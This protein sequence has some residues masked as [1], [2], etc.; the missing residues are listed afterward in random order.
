MNSIPAEVV[1]VRITVDVM[2]VWQ[3]GMTGAGPGGTN[4]V[5]DVEL[6]LRQEGSRVKGDIIGRL[7]TS[8][9]TILPG[10]VPIEGT[11][12]ADKFSFQDVRGQSLRADFQVN[13]DEMI[14]SGGRLVRIRSLWTLRSKRCIM[15]AGARQ[16]WSGR[17][18]PVPVPTSRTRPRAPATSQRR[19]SLSPLHSQSEQMIS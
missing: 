11:V 5:R 18:R 9:G 7:G 16:P 3:G 4:Y 12:S 6:V 2:G 8:S 17:L 13:G 19:H 1:M 14:G 10:P 15:P